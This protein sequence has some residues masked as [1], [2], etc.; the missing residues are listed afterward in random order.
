MRWIRTV[1]SKPLRREQVAP[2]RDTVTPARLRRAQ[3]LFL[4]LLHDLCSWAGRTYGPVSADYYSL[5]T[6]VHIYDPRERLSRYVD[7]DVLLVWEEALRPWF[8][9]AQTVRE[10]DFDDDGELTADDAIHD[11][12]AGTVVLTARFTP[13][14]RT[15]TPGAQPRS[16]NAVRWELELWVDGEITRVRRAWVRRAT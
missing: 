3:G 15:A 8:Q 10:L 2:A 1:P 4:S 5:P 9:S 16:Q 6:L 14:L 11:P 13:R 12:R 7:P